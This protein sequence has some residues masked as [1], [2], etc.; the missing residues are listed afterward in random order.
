VRS[1]FRVGA[2]TS[3]IALGVIAIAA[4]VGDDP[5]TSATPDTPDTGA[6]DAT[7]ANEGGSEADADASD[8][9][10]PS[11]PMVTAG[12]S[13]TCALAANGD[14]WCWG[15]AGF[16]QAGDPE[17]TQGCNVKC[18]PPRKIGGLPK[19][20]WIAAGEAGTC[21]V[22]VNGAVWCF[23]KNEYRQMGFDTSQA[24]TSNGVTHPCQPVPKQV[25]SI[26]PM[27]RVA[28]GS[29]RTC[30]LT[31]DG[32][33]W[34]WGLNAHGESGQSPFTSTPLAPAPVAD[35]LRTNTQQ[36]ALSHGAHG[37]AIKE[38]KAYS[39]GAFFAG[40]LG[41]PKPPTTCTSFPC[42]P[43]PAP[44]RAA[45][46]DGGSDLIGVAEVA[47]GNGWG[48]ARGTNRTVFVWGNGELGFL[49]DGDGR[50][51]NG[52]DHFSP[53]AQLV[54]DVPNADAIYAKYDVACVRSGGD[55][56]CW[57]SNEYGQTGSGA[58]DTFSCTGGALP[59]AGKSRKVVLP[60]PVVQAAAGNSFVVTI[61]ANGDIYTWG[62]NQA[63][64]LGRLRPDL[65]DAGAAF[66]P[67][68]A[69]IAGIPSF[70]PAP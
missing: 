46:T 67:V 58:A 23:G 68:P 70:A 39:W 7:P 56:H 42:D 65:T 41:R 19:V 63:G 50:H 25:E 18:S 3:A 9:G 34:C 13:H 47:M 37:S 8:P 11:T 4:C 15:A 10:A 45:S 36:L 26:P 17:T 1:G 29:G 30:A 24:C 20:R 33:V 14:V 38:N 22:D 55:L 12:G 64:Q 60:E 27:T 61:L 44:V 52:T 66:D 5:D 21:A 54:P 48:I 49:H 57:G 43:A 51:P 35:P 59:C 69:K 16:G 40:S 6:T 62:R 31:T 53:F 28:L 32:A 2:G